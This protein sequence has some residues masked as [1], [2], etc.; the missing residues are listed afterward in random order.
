[1]A[2]DLVS[3]TPDLGILSAV[4]MLLENRVSGG[5]VID[6]SG[7]LVGVLSI[8]DC[9]RVA[10]SASYHKEPGGL[11]SEYMSADVET[12]DADTEIVEVAEIFL[13]SR[14]RRFPVVSEGDLVGM[15]SRYDVLS[16]LEDLW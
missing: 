12:I 9:L 7:A 11:V 2:T 14:Y 8:K 4:R 1:M 3:F 6:A 13:K 16:A 5:P 10:F 15:I